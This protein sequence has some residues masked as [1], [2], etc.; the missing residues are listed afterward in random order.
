MSVTYRDIENVEVE[1]YGVAEIVD[2]GV[3][4]SHHIY[5]IEVED[6]LFT[7]DNYSEDFIKKIWAYI[8]ANES[9]LR[10]ELEEDAIYNDNY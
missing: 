10:A 5:D 3:C 4:P 6:V 2:N 9:E 7:N 1:F 8:E